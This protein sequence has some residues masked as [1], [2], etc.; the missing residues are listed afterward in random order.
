MG[1]QILDWTDSAWAHFRFRKSGEVV[2]D[3]TLAKKN[4]KNVGTVNNRLGYETQITFNEIENNIQNLS[5]H[6][7]P[8]IK[9]EALTDEQQIANMV[10][11]IEST[12]YS[13]QQRQ[14]K[15]QAEQQRLEK[16]R[17]KQEAEELE[18]QRQIKIEKKRLEEEEKLRIQ[19]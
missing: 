5:I 2:S 16:E 14:L 13:V 10:N 1:N 17:I 6:G 4:R 19:Q 9:N 12:S 3:A 15:Q 7:T 11:E 8:A 18:R